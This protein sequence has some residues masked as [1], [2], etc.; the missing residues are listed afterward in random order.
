MIEGSHW[1]H[2]QHLWYRTGQCANLLPLGPE[3]DSL[4][5]FSWID[6]SIILT[7]AFDTIT[8]YER[9]HTPCPEQIIP[10]LVPG[11]FSVGRLVTGTQLVFLHISPSPHFVPSWTSP[12]WG[13]AIVDG[14]WT[15]LVKY[16]H[17]CIF[18]GLNNK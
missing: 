2:F 6:Y 13:R 9:Q 15:I 1:N 10:S 7:L 18:D 3:A 17:K 12:I 5:Q 8:I 4:S 14:P 16:T 11:Q